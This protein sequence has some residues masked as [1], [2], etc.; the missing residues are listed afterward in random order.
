[1]TDPPAKR[2]RRWCWLVAAALLVA[3]GGVAARHFYFRPAAVAPPVVE[4]DGVDPSVATAVRAARE[5]VVD[6][7]K[8]AEAWG[9]LGMVLHA[10]V[11]ADEALACYAEARQLD[12]AD[13]RWPYL[14]ANIQLSR[15]PDAAVPAL[16]RAVELAG[17]SPD[18][19]ALLRLADLLL[20]TDDRAGAA[21][22]Y[23]RLLAR[24]PGH[25]RA[26]LG[27]AR[28]AL[29]DGDAAA[30]GPHLAACVDSPLTRKAALALRAEVQARAGDAAG[31][32]ATLADLRRTPDDRPS[33]D[34]WLTAVARLK[35][36]ERQRRD[37]A[38]RLVDE[39][40]LGEAVAALRDLT[41][42]YPDSAANWVDLGFA[43][44]QGRDWAGAE[45]AL[46]KSLALDPNLARAWFYLGIAHHQ[47]GDRTAAAADFRAAVER[48]PDYAL[49]HFNLGVTLQEDGDDPGAIA[50]FVE[51]LRCQ[52]RQA[53][54]HA[55]LGEL[56]SKAGRTAEATDHLRRAVELNP[57]D[58]KSKHLLDKR[59]KP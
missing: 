35:G 55:R 23:W 34:P 16:R 2:P 8:S 56:L 50:A 33:P 25:V 18:A 24:Q 14:E 54:A 45:S 32:E 3:A 36:G 27:L 53:P 59:L 15:V 31:A 49:A 46:R 6:E 48:K 39:R 44:L 22:L 30:A 10:H 57:G 13:A 1:M 41:H 58:D 21:E 37:Q 47:R 38:G 9:R 42:D 43:L 28:L 51:A 26:R 52:P 20:Q 7:P 4:L 5:R 11:F 17:D 29:L 12:P 40:R 19:P